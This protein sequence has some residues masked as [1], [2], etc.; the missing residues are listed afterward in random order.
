[1]RILTVPA[2]S[3]A[4]GKV[5]LIERVADELLTEP[6][7]GVVA[8]EAWSLPFLIDAIMLG[9]YPE[10]PWVLEV[11][12]PG[13]A[14]EGRGPSEFAQHIAYAPLVPFES[15][16]LRGRS[17]AEIIAASGTAGAAVVGYHATGDPL[18]ILKVPA[19]LIIAGA[20]LGIAEALRIGLRAKVLGLM[21]V[22]DPESR[23][24][25]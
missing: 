24:E 8:I 10:F 25:R 1:V 4:A 17:L 5:P 23:E 7:P 21:G 11:P 2:R 6:A 14:R 22:P 9:R 3:L 13:A 20:A 12:F 19:G 15:S 16:P 18:M